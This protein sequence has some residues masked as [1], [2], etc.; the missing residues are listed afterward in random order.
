MRCCESKRAFFFIFSSENA[1][2]SE[3]S[4]VSIDFP[5]SVPWCPSWWTITQ[6][7]LRLDSKHLRE[8]CQVAAAVFGDDDK[9]FYANTTHFRVVDAGLDRDYVAGDEILIGQRD[10]GGLVDLQSDPVPC[11]VKEALCER[12]AFLLIVYVCLVASLVQHVGDLAVDVPAVHARPYHGEGCLLALQDGVVHLLQPLVRLTLDEG[13][14]HVRVVAGRD[15]DGEDV[16]DYA[17]SRLQGPVAALVRV[18]RLRSSGDD[19]AV[20]GAAAPE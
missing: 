19:R 20:G 2:A 1:T 14:G 10:S 16:D 9:V 11:A 4:L 18:C 17:L 5:P 8:R 3:I 7:R 6:M 15:V 13:A 12:L